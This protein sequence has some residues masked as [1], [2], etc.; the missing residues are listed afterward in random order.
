MRY[1]FDNLNLL[2][3]EVQGSGS[4]HSSQT[5][6]SDSER[7]AKLRELKDKIRR[8]D[9][10]VGLFS[11]FL[12]QKFNINYDDLAPTREFVCPYAGAVKASL[13]VNKPFLPGRFNQNYLNCTNDRIMVHSA[14][15]TWGSFRAQCSFVESRIRIRSS[16]N[17]MQRMT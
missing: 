12:T 5:S 17:T 3:E 4:N 1:E 7:H 15:E 16:Q 2:V 14:D 9:N 6:P 11:E 13:K 8:M 10:F